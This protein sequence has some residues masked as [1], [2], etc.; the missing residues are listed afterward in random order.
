M[1]SFFR[2]VNRSLFVPV[3][4]IES[5]ENVEIADITTESDNHSFITGNQI[6][7]HNSSMAKQSLGYYVTN[8]NSR[9]DTLA[10]VLV[11][12]H[13]P[14]VATRLAKYVIMDKLPHGITSMLL[15]ACYTGYNQEDSIILNGDAVERGFFNTIYFRTYVAKA[16]KNKSATT[17]TERFTK[18]E[19]EKNPTR[20]AKISGS[21]DA[22]DREGVPI[23]GKKVYPGDVIIGKVIEMKETK[24]KEQEFIY[25]DVSVTIKQNEQGTVDKVI[26]DPDGKIL[27]YNAEGNRIVKARVSVLRKPEIGDKFA[28]R[29]SQKGTAGILYKSYNMPFTCSGL[30]PDMIMNPHGIPSR[31]TVGKLL[32]TLLGRVAVCTGKIQDATP[33]ISYNFDDFKQTLKSFGMDE[34]GNEVMYNGQTG[35]MFDVKFFYGPTY[36]QRL[37][38]M[39]D[40]KVHC[41][42]ADHEVLTSHGWKFIP[43]VTMNDEVAILK[44]GKLVYE[45]PTKVLHFPNYS[46]KMYCIKNQYVDLDVTDNHR[47]WVAVNNNEMWQPYQ[48]VKVNEIIG[49]HVKYQKDALWD[50]SDYQFELPASD[51]NDVKLF[52]MDAWLKFFGIWIATGMTSTEYCVQIPQYKERV[53][54]EVINKLGYKIHSVNDQITI[55][56]RQLYTY[57]SQYSCHVSQKYLPDWVWKLSQQQC[58][59]LVSHIQ[60]GDSCYY[61]SSNRLADDFMRL[62]LH[63]GWS[64]NKINQ[65]EVDHSSETQH[66]MWRLSIIKTKN[67]PSVN[68]GHDTQMEQLYDYTGSV[69]CLQVT[70]EVFYVRHHGL[71]VWT[72]NSRE[73]G[74][75]QLLTRQPAEG[76][77]RDGGLRLGEMER[78]CFIAHGVPKFLKERMMDSSDLFKVYVSKKEEAIV[79][80]N[81]DTNIFKYNGQPIKDDEIMQIQLPYAMKLLLQELESMGIDVR[82]KV[83]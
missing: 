21:Y 20:D 72:G 75:V 39:V 11:Y 54:F 43:D 80:G 47:M 55:I 24:E 69:Y 7:V 40:D 78:D 6:C 63:A 64:S 9:M 15:Y 48:L 31:M 3:D 73:S 68:H 26:P 41:L 1:F 16:V 2:I 27:P 74:P 56:D 19:P 82:L 25:R 5:C 71:P 79:V 65:F 28:S 18:P 34:L 66:N 32:E 36:Y 42:K 38:H 23:I 14:L 81:S 30:V 29:Y 49:K 37:R 59:T 83:T 45:K 53:I 62:C 12:G 77:S 44:E 50:H 13:K 17:A 57:M 35:Q 46:G 70:S 22:I 60:L 4:K 67:Q 10:H 61:T 52:E 33:F 58:Q 51:G 8:Y 76:R